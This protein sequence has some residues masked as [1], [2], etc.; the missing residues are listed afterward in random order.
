MSPTVETFC[1]AHGAKDFF[2]SREEYEQFRTRFGEE[3]RPKLAKLREAR[4]KSEE[5]ARHRYIG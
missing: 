5:Y 4:R 1:K 2:A 3:L